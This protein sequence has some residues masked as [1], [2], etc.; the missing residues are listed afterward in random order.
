MIPVVDAVRR[1]LLPALLALLLCAPWLPGLWRGA[2][3]HALEI[4]VESSLPGVAELRSDVGHGF[5]EQRSSRGVV[6]GTSGSETLRLAIPDGAVRALRLRL[7]DR[8]GG[9]RLVE[10]RLIR[11]D[12]AVL[13]PV[14]PGAWQPVSS[15]ASLRV[16]RNAVQI[17]PT[18][19]A[20]EVALGA[21]FRTPLAL[22]TGW[23]AR[24][25]RVLLLV[26]PVWLL[27]VALVAWLE[28]VDRR[29]KV[30]GSVAAW[31][32]RHPRLALAGVALIA[33]LASA[34]PVVFLGGSF[35]SA[36]SGAKLLYDRFPTVP[37][38]TAALGA[39]VRGADSGALLWQHLPGAEVQR[40]ALAEG[41]LPF[42]NRYNAAGVDLLAQG[43]SMFG[44]PLHL[45]VLAAGG[46]PWAWDL[47]FLA[48]RFL[49]IWGMGLLAWRA[50]RS[51]GAAAWVGAASGFVGFYV[52]R[53]I[54]PA[55]F[56][57]G[58]APWVLLGWW[59][60]VDAVERRGRDR[61][62]AAA[63]LVTA[64]L[65]LVLSGTV[66]EAVVLSI[67]LHAAGLAVSVAECPPGRRRA[68]T[69][70]LL[71]VFSAALLAAPWWLPFLD[72]LRRSATAYDVPT[73]FQI[74][75]GLLLGFFDEIFY[76]PL[77]PGAQ[78]TNP[79]ANA[80]V[81]VGLL[82]LVAT[83]RALR[84][85]RG[86][87]V[88][89]WSLVPV[90]AFTFGWVPPGWIA[91]VPFLGGVSHWDNCGS[92]ALLVLT[93]P[94]AAC[95]WAGLG[96]RLRGASASAD[97][98]GVALGWAA[99]LAVWLGTLQ[100]VPKVLPGVPSGARP[101]L[102]DP[103]V[104]AW[105]WVSAVLLPAAALG[106]LAL[107]RAAVRG[108][109]ATTTAVL[110]LGACA[111]VLLWRHGVHAPGVALPEY[112]VTAA[113][114]EPLAQPSAALVALRRDAAGEPS[115]V[116][117]VQGVLTPGWNARLGL[118]GLSGPDALMNR[119][120]RELTE[121]LGLP[122]FLDWR[123]ITE[124]ETFPRLRPAWAMLGVRYLLD[125]GS[126]RAA[127]A[128]LL[129]TV[130]RADLDV[131]RDATAWPRAFFVDAVVPHDGVKALA[132][133]VLASVGGPFA[134]V[135][136]AELR[137]PEWRDLA[138][139][140]TQAPA[141]ARPARRVVLSSNATRVQIEAPAAGLAVLHEAWLDGDLEVTR[142]GAPAPV[143]RV[144]HAFAGV[145]L[146]TAGLW[147]LEFRH[148]PRAWT[149]SLRLAAAGILLLSGTLLWMSLRRAGSAAKAAD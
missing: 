89:A 147:E 71:A 127:L 61:V 142:N 11:P 90:A 73:V 24:V 41:E 83:W 3:R 16:D 34:Y 144:N 43:Q 21:A 68:L 70:P 15:V 131:Y 122:R 60:A 146:P 50:S 27:L 66:K 97:L 53:V 138:L 145:V 51:L 123:I 69:W 91:R 17:E 59:W 19:S 42:W 136:E 121:A 134:G 148:R 26:L 87:V 29:T 86:A 78:V 44:D 110:G 81:L 75:P 120:Y 99:L 140:R 13:L 38:S 23:L 96:A 132:A 137:R 55:T 48:A 84:P 58:Y 88:L 6:Q 141:P 49:F 62:A 45:L 14:P 76:R 57:V 94:L 40:A 67:V 32:A 1:W 18:D 114:R 8:P 65:C 103:S 56:T 5:S 101:L 25:G 28:R 113:P 85:G 35:V 108:R 130:V 118:E 93:G 143:L 82:G 129:P 128:P 31:S 126:G 107:W 109:V 104:P 92:L 2:E 133:R 52:Y 37:Q 135:D 10:A 119:R 95:G 72:A 30:C 54:H 12:G 112:V 98:R 22:S 80:V 111:A 125:D 74:P 124:A 46:E 116:V 39:E 102:A 9:V 77:Q 64:S 7:L 4:V 139:P 100:A 115:R 149:L 105:V 33:T 106:G 36:G 47:R 79:S 117:G 63:V 20:T